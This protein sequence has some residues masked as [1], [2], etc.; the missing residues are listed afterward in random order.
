MDATASTKQFRL[1]HHSR[2]RLVRRLVEPWQRQKKCRFLDINTPASIL[3]GSLLGYQ[4]NIAAAFELLTMGLLQ[5]VC[6]FWEIGPCWF[7][8]SA[9]R[10]GEYNGL[11]SKPTTSHAS[12]VEHM[13]YGL[14]A[15]SR[16]CMSVRYS[17]GRIR[18]LGHS[19]ICRCSASSG[20]RGQQ[21][22]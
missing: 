7:Q 5:S 17:R 10:A 22:L 21:R 18:A 20:L 13:A 3:V 1:G 16:D 19:I 12:I 15:T 9:T 6:L 4:H 2:P 8:I 11:T 14:R